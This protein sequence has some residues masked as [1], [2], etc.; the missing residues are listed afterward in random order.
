MNVVSAYNEYR[1]KNGFSFNND[2]QKEFK[3][4]E[5]VL[6]FLQDGKP[7]LFKSASEGNI[8]VQI[9]NVASQPNQTLNRMLYSFTS[10]ANEVAEDSLEN[11]KKYMKD[12]TEL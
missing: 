10:T 5:K 8:I 4:R 12:K 11:Y 3:F 9:M 1:I 2:F 6:E 7:K